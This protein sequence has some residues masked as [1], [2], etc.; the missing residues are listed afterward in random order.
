MLINY[1]YK[2]IMK[3][4]YNSD[5]F[6]IF[7]K[8]KDKSIDMVLV[9][10]PYG[11]TECEWDVPIDLNT[12]WSQLKRIGKDNCQYVFFTTTKYGYD[13]IN[14]NKRCFRYDLVW[15]KATAVGFLNCK[16]QP[17]RAHEMI[18]I[19]NNSNVDDVNIEFNK[20]MRDYARKVREYINLPMCQLKK[21]F[22]NQSFDHFMRYN[23]SQFQLPTETCYN[24]LIELYKIDMMDGFIPFNDLEKIKRKSIKHTYNPQKIEGKAYHSKRKNIRSSVYGELTIK[25][26]INNG[27]RY[28][29]SVQKFHVK[30]DKIHPTQKP[31][32]LCEF[33]IKSYSNEGD[34][35]LDF[36]MGSGSTIEACINTNRNY[37]GI[38]KDNEIYKTAR[39]RIKNILS[40]DK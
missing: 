40:I 11:Q 32:G 16:N 30:E 5:C 36:C 24:K 15:E 35:V 31:L 21:D 1:E 14:S 38:E 22:G 20:D 34:V 39:T 25:D 9:D 3:K 4:L 10:L 37:I 2:N 28:P 18:Y 33:L 29:R 27:D 23:G 8:I 6:S 13:L 12:M 17:L 19:F 7:P 26:L